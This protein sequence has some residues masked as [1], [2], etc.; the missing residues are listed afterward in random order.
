MNRE[1]LLDRTKASES[2]TRTLVAHHK[3][4][5]KWG[6]RSYGLC[7]I[8]KNKAHGTFHQERDQRRSASTIE[9]GGNKFKKDIG[10]VVQRSTGFRMH[11]ASIL[12][13]V[14]AWD[15]RGLDIPSRRGPTANLYRLCLGKTR[16][17]YSQNILLERELSRR[18]EFGLTTATLCGDQM[19]GWQYTTT[20]RSGMCGAH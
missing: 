11:L 17:L 9:F 1:F 3:L 7:D 12:S 20:I 18:K 6:T 5:S 14:S 13:S 8:P 2:L 15:S 4:L 19:R 16:I 10:G